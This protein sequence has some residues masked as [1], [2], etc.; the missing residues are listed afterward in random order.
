MPSDGYNRAEMDIYAVL[1]R[2]GIDFERADHPAVFTVEEARNLVPE[3]PGVETKNL[4]VRDRKGGRH[5]L[6]VVG[7]G[8]RVDLKAM[9]SLLACRKLSLGSPRRLK[10]H[11]G[12]EPGSVSILAVAND[13]EGRVEVVVDRSLWEADRW[14][15]HPLINTSTLVISRE[16]IARFLEA[17]GHRPRILEAPGL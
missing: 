7:Y 9:A 5:F 2:L 11:L 16:D 1:E 14:H 8:K 10:E 3:L 6:I 12:I 15:C 4:F 13:P 17:T